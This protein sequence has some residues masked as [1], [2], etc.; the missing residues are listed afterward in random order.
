MSVAKIVVLN[1]RMIDE[2]LLVRDVGRTMFELTDILYCEL[3]WKTMNYMSG[4]MVP[5]LIFEQGS[6]S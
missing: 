1:G 2:Y 3:L 6:K 4:W 5:W